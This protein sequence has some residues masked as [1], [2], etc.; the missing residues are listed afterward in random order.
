[1]KSSGF[2]V[3][4]LLVTIVLTMFPNGA[5]AQNTSMMIYVEGSDTYH[6]DTYI[7]NSEVGMLTYYNDEDKLQWTQAEWFSSWANEYDNQVYKEIRELQQDGWHFVIG[8][9]I[10]QGSKPEVRPGGRPINKSTFVWPAN[11]RF[12]FEFQVDDTTTQ[13]ERSEKLFVTY[14]DS[15]IAWKTLGP[16]TYIDDRGMEAPFW[17]ISV[18]QNN[19]V[20]YYQ[21]YVGFHCRRFDMG[22]IVRAYIAPVDHLVSTD[23]TS[24]VDK[25]TGV[26]R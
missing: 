24:V 6:Y 26:E 4:V 18:S 23:Q 16:V 1:M 13:V 7:D 21:F 3:V 2:L 17:T 14:A 10:P 22:N 8:C 12:F 9:F 11:H 20:V 5:R 25:T 15:D 19:C